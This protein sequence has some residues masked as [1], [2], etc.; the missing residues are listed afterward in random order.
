M[1]FRSATFSEELSHFHFPSIVSLVA[2]IY[3]IV[4]IYLPSLV[5]AD[6]NFVVNLHLFFF[7]TIEDLFEFVNL[8]I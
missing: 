3:C 7:I 5:E 2:V 4:I 6:T 1:M 8:R